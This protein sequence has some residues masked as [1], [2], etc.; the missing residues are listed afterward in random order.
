[1][2]FLA[3][4]NKQQMQV[5]YRGDPNIVPHLQSIREQIHNLCRFHVN[6]IVRVQT[7]DGEVYEGTIVSCD[8]RHLYLSIDNS[9]RQYGYDPYTPI[10]MSLVLYELLLITLLSIY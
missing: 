9:N 1:M 4:S 8:K 5:L 2:S 7:I 6:K 3:P 10:I